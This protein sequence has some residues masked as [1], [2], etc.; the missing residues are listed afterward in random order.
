MLL[1]HFVAQLVPKAWST[2]ASSVW[3]VGSHFGS[4]E[5]SHPHA[6]SWVKSQS[7]SNSYSLS[8]ILFIASN[9]RS[10]PPKSIKFAFKIIIELI[11][12]FWA[13]LFR[14]LWGQV[15]IQVGLN[16]KLDCLLS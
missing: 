12:H 10:Q 2:P 15:F 8:K 1:I 16:V 13:L 7:D 3:A 9:P 14:I 11:S 5:W 6:H 4:A